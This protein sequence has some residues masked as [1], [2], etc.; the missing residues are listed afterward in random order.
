MSEALPTIEMTRV[1]FDEMIVS[2]ARKEREYILSVFE[3]D[4]DQRPASVNFEIQKLCAE[5]RGE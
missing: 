4:F 2:V 5:V 3:R 1:V